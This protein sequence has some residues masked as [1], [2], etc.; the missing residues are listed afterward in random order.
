M[1]INIEYL[2]NLAVDLPI[3]RPIKEFVHLNLLLRYQENDFWVAIKKVGQKLE[4]Y[5]FNSVKFYQELFQKNPQLKELLEER[6]LKRLGDKSAEGYQRLLSGKIEFQHHDLRVAPLHDAWNKVMKVNI[7]DMTDNILIKWLSHFLDQGIGEWEMPEAQ[8]YSFFEVVKRMLSNAFILPTPFKKGLLK[9]LLHLD[10][11]DLIDELLP[12]LCPEEN[13]R[14]EYIKESIMTL[15]GWAGLIYSVQE[16]PDLLAFKRTI[17]LLDFI[18]VK[19]LIEYSWIKYTNSNVSVPAFTQRKIETGLP[20]LDFE[21][22]RAC[23]EVY[24]ENVFDEYLFQLKKTP[25]VEKSITPAY[26]AVFCMDDRET[27]LRSAAEKRD[28]HLKTFG[29]AG[30]YGLLMMYHHSHSAFSKK[31]CPTPAVPTYI[32][33]ETTKT[34]LQNKKSLDYVRELFF[35]LWKKNLEAIEEVEMTSVLDV[36]RS[37]ESVTEVAGLKP[38]Y[39]FEEGADLIYSQ[40]KVIGLLDLAELV[41]ITGHGSTSANNQYFTA[42]GCGACSGRA[43]AVNARIFCLM[44]NEPE[45][46]K[47]IKDKYQFEIPVNTYFQAAFHDTTQDLLRIF[48]ISRLPSHLKA[49]Y[50][51]FKSNMAKALEDNAKSRVEK[52]YYKTFDGIKET[53][54]RA[55]SFFQPRPELGHTNVSYSIVG[56]RDNFKHITMNRPAFFQSYDPT[57]DPDA[58]LLT[59]S[60]SAVI[61]VTSGINLDYFFSSVDN[62]RLG[63]GSKLPQNVVGHFGVSHGTESDLRF[64]LPYQMIDQN[65]ATRIFILVEQTPELAL[66]AVKRHA[67][68]Y[69]IVSNAWIYYGSYDVVSGDI[70]V[71][72]EGRMKK[73][74]QMGDI[75]N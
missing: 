23:Q 73:I 34:K 30:H 14:E 12:K 54:F 61:P 41:V 2:N 13:L 44:A 70:H 31:H 7:T 63:A 22:L 37:D 55:A 51:S 20:D 32:I 45:I 11:Q 42:Y 50:H 52:F 43:G 48:D 39:T 38:G 56:R 47:I 5:P 1:K 40:L 66:L 3:I 10:S 53:R 62:Q 59:S 17:S 71:Y 29:A 65:R 26:Q 68:L 4:A 67:G 60:L 28:P 58:S 16:H 36:F 19:C 46:R 6:L 35:P 21:I 9:E 72:A 27:P 57:I 74:N 49:K 64:G 25:S 24:E 8:H 33:R 15:R 75:W 18:A 69:Q